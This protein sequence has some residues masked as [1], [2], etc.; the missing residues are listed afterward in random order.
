[1]NY[2]TALLTSAQLILKLKKLIEQYHGSGLTGSGSMRTAT[3]A[4]RKF[5]CGEV[6]S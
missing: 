6:A 2:R 1:M 3:D 4:Y 5:L